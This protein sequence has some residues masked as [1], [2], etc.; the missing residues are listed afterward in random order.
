MGAFHVFQI[1][2]MVQIGQSITY[3]NFLKSFTNDQIVKLMKS[4]FMRIDFE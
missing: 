1:V 2:Q 4:N 3:K